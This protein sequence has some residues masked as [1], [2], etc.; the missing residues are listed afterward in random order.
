MRKRKS[1]QATVCKSLEE[2]KA[3][4]ASNLRV[5]CNVFRFWW[6]CEEKL[7]CRNKKCS[8]DSVACFNRFW[9]QVPERMKVAFRTIVVTAKER[10]SP[11]ELD[12]RVAEALARFDAIGAAEADLLSP[13]PAERGEGAERMRG[14]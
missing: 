5:V 6:V 3:E 12:R 1:R 8:G 9:P 4:E 2:A 14:G 13:R 11:P 7:C 10:L